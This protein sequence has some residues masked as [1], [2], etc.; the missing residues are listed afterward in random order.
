MFDNLYS[1]PKMNP[2]PSSPQ[3]NLT[4][5]NKTIFVHHFNYTINSVD[6]D[7]NLYRDKYTEIV[8]ISPVTMKFKDKNLLYV[9]IQ[10]DKKNHP[11]HSYYQGM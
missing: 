1:I 3:P 5:P 6:D 11:Q 7:I 9:K 10:S 2:H 4:Q 8:G